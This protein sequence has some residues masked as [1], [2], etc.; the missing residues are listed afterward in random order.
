MATTK[1]NIV[2]L[3]AG[4][5]G[6]TIATRL[7]AVAAAGEANVT[8][9]ESRPALSVGGLYQFVLKRE[10]EARDVPMPYDGGASLRA[11]A[12]DFL[13]DEVTYVDTAAREVRTRSHVLPY[14]Y[15]AITAGARYVPERIP[16]L[17]ECA[18]NIGDL[19]HVLQ[20]RAALDRFGGGRILMSIP[21]LPYKCPTVPQEFILIV[22]TIVG[23]LDPAI[24]A[25]TE[26]VLTTEADGPFPMTGF[27]LKRFEE[28]GIDCVIFAPIDHVDPATRTV[29]FGEG[30]DGRVVEPMQFDI[31]MATFPL[32]APPAFANLCNETGM[33]P[34]DPRSLRTD[35]DGV[36][37]MG[38][39]A[40]MRLASG[41]LHPKAGAFA[42][43]QAEAAAANIAALVRSAGGAD[44]SAENLG[45]A[46]CEAE[47][48]N[49]EGVTVSV[50]LMGDPRAASN[51][52][53]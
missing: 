38:D 45:I 7:D 11:K 46:A 41:P 13:A 40:A 6:L 17:A 44:A 12:V 33:I 4:F 35:C 32:A 24:R 36:W 47:V 29:H 53:R 43:C 2:V 26:F 31:M 1:P 3:G 16:G 14:D 42:A 21:S 50:N 8:L 49:H 18:Y 22:E 23:E 34:S 5:A 20:L 52:A 15:L 27:F 19:D 10:V 25:K 51:S 48:G 30:R 37:A 39:C 9:V 28:R